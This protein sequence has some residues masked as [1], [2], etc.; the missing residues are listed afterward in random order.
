L[1]V[2]LLGFFV[3]GKVNL[4]WAAT[5]LALTSLFFYGYWHPIY[6]GLL[7]ISVVCNYAFGTRLGKTG[8]KKILIVAITANLS[9]LGY[10]KY[11]NFFVGSLD[12]LT[13][14]NWHINLA[15]GNFVLYLHPNWVFGRHLSG[16]SERI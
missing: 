6:V 5:W 2:V 11:V 13:G 14:S 15:I 4:A 9:L 8:S 16:Q 12:N 3:L 7:I 10:Y 1:P